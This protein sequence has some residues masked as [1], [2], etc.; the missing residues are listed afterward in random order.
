M[1]SLPSLPLVMHAALLDGLNPLVLV[2]FI[3]L[4][5]LSATRKPRVLLSGS[6]FCLGILFVYLL[7]GLEE[8]RPLF[9]LPRLAYEY[10]LLAIGAVIVV[11]GLRQLMH[12][13]WPASLSSPL[14]PR[15]KVD[16]NSYVTAIGALML[17]IFITGATLPYTGATYLAII[18]MAAVTF[19]FHVFI[20]LVVYSLAVIIP[21]VVI[22]MII[23]SA[24]IR[25]FTRA[26]SSLTHRYVRLGAGLLLVFL[27]WLL[28]L[29]ANG[30]INFG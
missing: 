26:K 23:A 7:G 22:L 6:I 20:L 14:L 17:G 8:I 12:F 16:M 10:I 11:A 2:L 13:F 1:N 29:M 15:P 4:L 18:T 28:M 27:G 19:N 25:S 21:E 9:D 3:A 5:L 24:S 30:T